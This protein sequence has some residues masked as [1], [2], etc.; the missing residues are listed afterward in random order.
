MKS[1]APVFHE[2]VVT[3]FSS[4]CLF[5]SHFNMQNSRAVFWG[6]TDMLYLYVKGLVDWSIFAE[7]TKNIWPSYD[8]IR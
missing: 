2:A 7:M 1:I 3:V 8:G 4:K 5:R 6:F